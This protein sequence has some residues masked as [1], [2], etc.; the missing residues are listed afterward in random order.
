MKG[1]EEAARASTP[2]GAVVP[3]PSSLVQLRTTVWTGDDRVTRPEAE[4][5]TALPHR[6]AAIEPAFRQVGLP[7]ADIGV[8]FHAPR[9]D[10]AVAGELQHELPVAGAR[11]VACALPLKEGVAGLRPLL[12]IGPVDR[13]AVLL[14][15]LPKSLFLFRRIVRVVVVAVLDA[16]RLDRPRLRERSPADLMVTARIRV[17]FVEIL[18]KLLVSFVGFIVPALRVDARPPRRR[19]HAVECRQI[20]GEERRRQQPQPGGHAPRPED[21]VTRTVED[22]WPKEPGRRIAQ[23][24]GKAAPRETVR[25]FGDEHHR[26]AAFVVARPSPRLQ[27]RIAK[28]QQPAR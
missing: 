21:D 9:P 25:L 3:W 10:L 18:P 27:N 5:L 23:F 24:G 1:T 7:D 19:Q 13:S 14:S 17:F 22:L 4:Q 6:P 20:D 15:A 26:R 11:E 16:I 28:E 2:V 12:V 8:A